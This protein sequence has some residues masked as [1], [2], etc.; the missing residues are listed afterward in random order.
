M[1][2]LTRSGAPSNVESHRYK[3]AIIDSMS[4]LRSIYS[5]RC[6]TN[7]FLLVGVSTAHLCFTL[8]ML[9]PGESP[10]IALPHWTDGYT[11]I[12]CVSLPSPL[13]CK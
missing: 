5:S 8:A 2:L 4:S 12:E 6:D 10:E 13:T 1:I 7:S 11:C 9:R 3:T